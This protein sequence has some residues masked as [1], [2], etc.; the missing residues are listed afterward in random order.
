MGPAD[1]LCTLE[2]S[3]R[4]AGKVEPRSTTPMRMGKKQTEGDHPGKPGSVEWRRCPVGGDRRGSRTNTD[5]TM[6]HRNPD[7]GQTYSVTPALPTV[8]R[9]KPEEKC[10]E[11][12]A[13]V[14]QEFDHTTPPPPHRATHKATR[15]RLFEVETRYERCGKCQELAI[16]A[17]IQRPR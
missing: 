1:G 6:Y 5:G 4:S 3:C 15:D 11:I 14:G 12:P 9:L 10:P 16:D 2:G 13:S 8:P 17:N 7:K